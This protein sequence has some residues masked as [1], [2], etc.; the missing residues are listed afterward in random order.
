MRRLISIFLLLVFGMPLAL[1]A[2]AYTASS[3][4]ANLPACCKR[5]GVHHCT[6]MVRDQPPSPDPNVSAIHEKCPAYPAVVT[7]V[8]HG[9]LF[10]P[11][12]SLIDA[13]MR[14][15]SSLK[16][17]AASLARISFLSA[18]QKRGP[19]TFAAAIL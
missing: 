13:G 6:G 10:I 15:H 16:P 9:N 17:R 11:T 2:L 3:S 18:C 14:T 8:Q 12:A 19:P 1:P 5:N 7:P 4:E